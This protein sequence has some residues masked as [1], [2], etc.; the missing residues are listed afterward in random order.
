M[1]AR[2]MTLLRNKL[3]GNAEIVLV[4]G[5]ASLFFFLQARYLHEA[6]FS[7]SDEG[8]HAQV[9]RMMLD[10]YMPYKDFYYTH[11]PILPLF[12]GLNIKFFSSI[13][14][15][16]IIYL[17]L[18]CFSGILL[19]FVF[20]NIT[21]NKLA[22]LVGTLFYLT[23]HQM[24]F[25]NFRFIALRQLSNVLLI[26]FLYFGTVKPRIRFSFLSQAL[27]SVLNALLFF[28]STLIIFFMS[29][30]MIM[31]EQSERLRRKVLA[32]YL[33]IGLIT[34]AVLLLF[35]L[36]VPDS[37]KL[38]VLEHLS[39]R[40]TADRLGRIYSLFN[41]ESKNYFFHLLS[42]SSLVCAIFFKEIRYYA[43]ASLGVIILVFLPRE[44]FPHYFDI[45]GP[46]LAFGAC[47][48]VVMVCQL[49]KKKYAPVA[50]GICIVALTVQ[51]TITF[52]SLL[53]E[54]NGNRNTE[55]HSLVKFLKEKPEPFLM[56]FE[57]IFAV[58]ANKKIV[59]HYYLSDF[60]TYGSLLGRRLTE[61]EYTALAN[62]ACTIVLVPWDKGYV[63]SSIQSR[64]MEQYRHHEIVSW[65]TVLTT[66]NAHCSSA[67]NASRPV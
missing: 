55:Y 16:R 51:I 40:N 32:R 26:G 62:E 21:K 17:F 1:F 6:A 8:V 27:L 44:F 12:I 65:A 14:S 46:A 3:Q 2:T 42:I 48:F 57:P 67:K 45:A 30:A 18:N 39:N 7:I 54:W 52:P 25:Y 19:Y 47:T 41:S 10:G 11:P 63:P 35:F 24:V 37:F 4:V 59:Y 5:I 15:A 53:K 13:Y 23:Y 36:I 43:I 28:Q 9:G 29:L 60:R 58:E 22:A 64:W 56:F 34:I 33:D 49:T 38:T 20:K 31:S 50:Y 61:K 66:D